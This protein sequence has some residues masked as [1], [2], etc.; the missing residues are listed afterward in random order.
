MSFYNAIITSIYN[1]CSGSYLS[2]PPSLFERRL[3]ACMQST[4]ILSGGWISRRLLGTAE[5]T[6]Q[7]L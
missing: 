5:D 3:A 4:P 2:S 1:V 6:G 7:R